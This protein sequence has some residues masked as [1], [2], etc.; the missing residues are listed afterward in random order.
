VSEPPAFHSILAVEDSDEDFVALVRAFRSVAPGLRVD[1]CVDGDEAL[2]YLYR[3]G[4]YTGIARPG[5]VVLDLNL[6]G[7]DGHEVLAVVKGDDDL[8]VLP[9]II[10]TSSGS[11]DDL[12][13]AY[14]GGANCYVQKTLDPGEFRRR[15]LALR[16]FWLD[17]V[18]LP[19]RSE[20]ERGL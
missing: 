14:R 10:L 20:D 9:I 5:L 18:V 2:D 3:R 19:E 12:Q 11:A 13:E 6:P 7:T 1:R 16:S 4:E 17:A 8:R 15:I